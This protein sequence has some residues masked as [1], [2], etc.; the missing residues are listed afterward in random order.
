VNDSY[1][2][3]EGDNRC[4]DRPRLELRKF[5]YQDARGRFGDS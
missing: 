4:R 1:L 3:R 5:W 2:L